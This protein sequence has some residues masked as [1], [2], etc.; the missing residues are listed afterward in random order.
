MTTKSLV[1]AVLLTFSSAFAFGM[2]D[3]KL[4]ELKSKSNETGSK[5]DENI[6]RTIL[7][8]TKFINCS[9]TKKVEG[10]IYEIKAK[11]LLSGQEISFTYDSGY[12]NNLFYFENQSKDGLQSFYMSSHDVE[13]ETKKTPFRRDTIILNIG[14]DSANK[15][16]IEMSLNMSREKEVQSDLTCVGTP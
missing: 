9:I 3:L 6:M 4:A 16:I 14:K 10:S 13:T 11:S 7:E 12:R 5:V 2:T 1:T 15:S 8:K